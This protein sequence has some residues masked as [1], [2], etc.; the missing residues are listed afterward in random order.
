MFVEKSKRDK[1]ELFRLVNIVPVSFDEKGRQML[2]NVKKCMNMKR[3]AI[4]AEEH[5]ELRI[6]TSDEDMNLDNTEYTMDLLDSLRL[7]FKYIIY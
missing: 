2:D 5:P 1:I 6:A 4:D 3:I 7:A